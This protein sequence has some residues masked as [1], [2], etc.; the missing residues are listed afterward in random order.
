MGR[1]LFY[2]YCLKV[3]SRGIRFNDLLDA[4]LILHL[5]KCLWNSA[6]K[7][8]HMLENNFKPKKKWKN[9]HHHYH[10]DHIEFRYIGRQFK[11]KQ[12]K[13]NSTRNWCEP[14]NTIIK[15]SKMKW[16]EV[17]CCALVLKQNLSRRYF[18]IPSLNFFIF[19]FLF[20]LISQER[21]GQNAK[22]K[23]QKT[24]KK[25]IF[26][27]VLQHHHY[28]DC[29][30]TTTT[31]VDCLKLD[32]FLLHL[33]VEE[34]QAVMSWVGRLAGWLVGSLVACVVNFSACW[35]L[36]NKRRN[37]KK[38]KKPKKEKKKENCLQHINNVQQCQVNNNS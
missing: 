1:S 36:F 34:R 27:F 6:Y 11:K 17:Q 29:G 20:L 37:R 33:R 16:S 26:V 28:H 24:T 21:Q 32:F 35:W 25:D 31:A 3:L 8:A 19:P 7:T 22:G 5:L 2:I 9:P 4:D 18:S 30:L 10:R 14:R 13:K 12:K 38:K 15:W 23:E